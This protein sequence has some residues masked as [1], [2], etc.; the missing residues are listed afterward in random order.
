M[1]WI[2]LLAL[3]SSGLSFLGFLSMAGY[4]IWLNSRK[5]RIK[6]ESGATE[7]QVSAVKEQCLASSD[8]LRESLRVLLGQLNERI[9][10][11]EQ[12]AAES[13]ATLAEELFRLVGRVNMFIEMTHERAKLRVDD[14]HHPDPEHGMTDVLL[15]KF[16]N[17][18]LRDE[19]EI[20]RLQRVMA[21]R[22]SDETLPRDERD[23]ATLIY[24]T[25]KLKY[26]V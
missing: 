2:P 20:R 21:E 24:Y 10:Q 4:T 19:R 18:S 25:L 11:V 15:D 3:V 22:K 26:P 16:R 12:R 14:V 9:G 8:S 5:T 23:A 1:T 13:R 17:D 6:G 7:A